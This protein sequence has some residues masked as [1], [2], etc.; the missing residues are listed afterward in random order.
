[1]KALTWVGNQAVAVYNKG[2]G[3]HKQKGNLVKSEQQNYSSQ[4]IEMLPK[5]HV[6]C[7]CDLT[8]VEIFPKYKNERHLCHSCDIKSVLHKKQK[9]I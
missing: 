5:M 3:T 4:K 2:Q 7:N 8:K 1:M 9:D 6:N